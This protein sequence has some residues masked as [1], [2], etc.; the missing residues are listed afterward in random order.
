M[1]AKKKK[2][3]QVSIAVI[4]A[5]VLFGNIFFFWAPAPEQLVAGSQDGL[6]QVTGLAR[7]ESDLTVERLQGVQIDVEGA[8]GPA[9]ELLL[10]D[11]R[12]EQGEIKVF[13]DESVDIT[14]VVLYQ[15][16]RDTL[17]WT[18]L[19]TGFDLTSGSVSA[20]IEFYGS[21]LVVAASRVL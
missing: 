7:G 18:Q 20:V 6:V 11:G 21:T 19:A 13:L 16:N 17:T 15:F 5:M 14:E 1:P 8:L 10:T 4:V 3:T 2:E 9:Y 12:L